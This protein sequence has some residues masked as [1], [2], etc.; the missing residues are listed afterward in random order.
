MAARR[1]RTTES[2]GTTPAPRRRRTTKPAVAEP[3]KKEEEASQIAEEFLKELHAEV[4]REEEAQRVE[5]PLPEVPKPQIKPEPLKLN[6]QPRYLTRES[7][8]ARYRRG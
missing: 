3:V 6:R 1:R 8:S 5:P 2:T 7:R 4:E